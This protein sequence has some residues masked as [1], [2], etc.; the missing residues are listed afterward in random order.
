[1]I[2]VY[3]TTDTKDTAKKIA[4]HLLKKRLIACANIFPIDSM[5]W[6]NG[7]IAEDAEF[8]VI[9]KTRADKFTEIEKEVKKMHPYDNPCIVVWNIEKGSRDYLDWIGRETEK[10]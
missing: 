5:Y 3:I 7:K 6:W 8:A 10:K 4:R 1:M 2:S 9:L